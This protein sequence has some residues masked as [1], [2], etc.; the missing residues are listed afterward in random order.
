MTLKNDIWKIYETLDWQYFIIFFIQFAFDKKNYE[1]ILTIPHLA[2][3]LIMINWNAA[4]FFL[5]LEWRFSKEGTSI[6]LSAN[7][8]AVGW[9]LAITDVDLP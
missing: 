8:D 7:L 4:S 1:W 9:R 6:T 2:K 3:L 5:A